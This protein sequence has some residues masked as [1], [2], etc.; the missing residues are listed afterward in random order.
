[1][2]LIKEKTN[3]TGIVG[4]EDST[5]I[6]RVQK[7]V[8]SSIEKFSDKNHLKKIVGNHLYNMKLS[9][10]VVKY[11]QKLFNYMIAQNHANIQGIQNGLDAMSKHPFDDHTSCNEK[12]CRHIQDPQKDSSPFHLANL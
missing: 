12:W 6:S 5:T 11:I 3:I 7:E 2:R 4:D 8:D 10:K 1:M 9:T